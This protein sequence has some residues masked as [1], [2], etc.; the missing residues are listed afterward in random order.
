MKSSA[1]KCQELNDLAGDIPAL[2][3]QIEVDDS[4]R[5]IVEGSMDTLR[6][7]AITILAIS[8]LSGAMLFWNEGYVKP[9][10]AHIIQTQG[11]V[12]IGQ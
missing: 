11:S 4:R 1:M 3:G 7:F 2:P 9:H 6:V 5:I 10:T 12:A 8:L